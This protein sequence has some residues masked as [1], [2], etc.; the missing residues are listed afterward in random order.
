MEWIDGNIGSKLNLKYPA[1]ILLGQNSSAKCISIA[2]S[3]KGVIQDTG[4]KMIHVGKETKSQI[5]SKSIAANGGN[6]SYRG[7]VEIRPTAIDSR[8]EVMC[9]SLILDSISKSDTFPTEIISNNSS[10]IKHEAKVTDIDKELLFYINTRGISDKQAK[11]L[12]VMGF[13]EPFAVELPLE[14]AVELNRL[15]KE[16]I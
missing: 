6:A 4:A 14:Y 11:H 7:M 2:T 5:I 15:I 1:T 10:F 16:L 8:A 13:I 3:N 9:D 12:I